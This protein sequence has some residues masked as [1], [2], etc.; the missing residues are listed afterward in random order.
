[1]ALDRDSWAAR[2]DPKPV[3]KLQDFEDLAAVIRAKKGR[4]DEYDLFDALDLAEDALE[5]ARRALISHQCMYPD[6]KCCR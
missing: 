1:M 6:H 2:H 3:F 5:E 4:Y